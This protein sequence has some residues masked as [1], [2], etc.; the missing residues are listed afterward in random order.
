MSGTGEDD[1]TLGE[2]LRQAKPSDPLPSFDELVDRALER[3][4]KTAR[5]RV[6]DGERH[7]PPAVA[8][9]VASE[10]DAEEWG[11]AM[12]AAREANPL[13]PN[14]FFLSWTGKEFLASGPGVDVVVI[15][16]RR[17]RHPRG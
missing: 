6:W 5:T 2:V 1:E 4:G 8:P 13:S 11:E 15:P 16:R 3:R 10:P 12:R 17:P 14:S 7:G 9:A